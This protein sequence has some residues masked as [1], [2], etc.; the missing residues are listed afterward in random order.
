[1]LYIFDLGNVIVDI[2]FNRVLG[3]W[4][5]LTRIPL[6]T[7]Q[8]HFTM[9][10]AFHQHERGEISDEDFAA[11][12][13]HEMNMS[14]SYEQFS[15]GWQ[16]VLSPSARRLSRLCKN[17]ASRG[18]GSWFCPTLTVCIPPSGRMSTPRYAPWLTISIFLRKWGCVNPKRGSIRASLKRKVFR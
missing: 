14:L 7:L 5:D 12:M 8:Q 9:G 17:Y 16:A 6:A 1:M 3:T 18:I 15:H 11:A 10:E 2:D 4:S 13:C